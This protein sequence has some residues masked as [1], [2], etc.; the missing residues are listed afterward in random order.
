[1]EEIPAV[2]ES[3]LAALET[4]VVGVDCMVVE[5]AVRVGASNRCRVWFCSPTV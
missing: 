1:M 3:K 4:D 2:E 5:I